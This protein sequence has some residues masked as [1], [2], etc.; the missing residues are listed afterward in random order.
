MVEE[1]WRSVLRGG[2]AEEPDDAACCLARA[3]GVG[4]EWAEGMYCSLP[5][6]QQVQFHA[7]GC[8]EHHWLVAQQ[9]YPCSK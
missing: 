4:W 6:A 9:N 7:T 3:V 5:A 8:S 1:G 2:L